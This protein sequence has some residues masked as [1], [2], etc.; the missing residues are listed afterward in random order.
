M[1]DLSDAIERKFYDDGVRVDLY[2]Q[3]LELDP[4]TKYSSGHLPSDLRKELDRL[5]DFNEEN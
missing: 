3:I 2:E 4:D 5:E 1:Q